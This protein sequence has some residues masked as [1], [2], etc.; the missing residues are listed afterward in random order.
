MNLL[1][2]KIF[3]LTDTLSS[4]LGRAQK[5]E[6]A[7]KE[8]NFYI[9]RNPIKVEPDSFAYARNTVLEEPVKNV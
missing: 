2:Y 5:F 3:Y 7:G 8:C 1:F 4:V 6:K 9:G